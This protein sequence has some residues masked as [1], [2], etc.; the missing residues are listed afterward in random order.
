MTATPPPKIPTA[1][2]IRQLTETRQRVLALP[3]ENAL[4]AILEHPQP[5]ALVHSFSEE[6]LHFLIH[7]IGLENAL[8]LLSLA[9]NRQWEYLVDMEA[10]SRDRMN[11][12]TTTAWLQLLLAADADRLVKWCYEEKLEWIELYLFRNIELRI[13]E[14][15]QSPSDL[16]EGYFSDDDTFYV[17]F[18][19][20]PVATQQEEAFKRLRNEMLGQLLRRLSLFDH[21]RYQGLL[22]EAMG[23]LPGEI[24]EELF[25]LR[26]VRLGEKGFLPFDEAV[27][28]YQPL[29]PE[30]LAARGKKI[31]RPG[32]ADETQLPAP[33]ITATFL[34]GDN[35]FVRSLKQIQAPHII[36]QLQTETASLCN[37]VIAADLSVIR[38]RDQL[39]S[40]V[41]KVSGYLSIGLGRL[42]AG[43]RQEREKKAAKL[44]QRHM[45]IDIF[46]TG[47]GCALQLK[48][49]ADRWY[50]ESWCRDRKLEL[51]FWGETWLGQLGGLLIDKPKF[52]DPDQAGSNYRDFAAMEEIEATGLGLSQ[53]TVLDSLFGKLNPE[54]APSSMHRSIDYKNMLLTQWARA[55]LKMPPVTPGTSDPAIPVSRFRPFYETLW[56]S[57]EDR[58]RIADERKTEFL[59]WIAKQ[60]GL[61]TTELADRLGWVFEALF[62]EIEQ[63]LARVR[64]GNLD[65]RHVHLFLLK[66]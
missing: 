20:Y 1:D 42:L 23:L 57:Q 34:E 51:T 28:V 9:S 14:S 5:A 15:D 16:G 60:S 24:E 29:Q 19:D 61:S 17:R 13:R 8:P 27:G 52:Y 64:A 25:R 48:W 41:S 30:E 53:V 43:S 44:V 47:F 21:L 66:P 55:S 54:L 46:R 18:V 26:N 22:M 45:L 38:G 59:Q 49:R 56:R 6:D 33:R 58:R 39:R 3:A 62:D 10:W 4:Q 50:R 7:D 37:R 36:E 32:P 11:F 35:L 12:Q 65:P 2:R 31:L 40:V 63:E